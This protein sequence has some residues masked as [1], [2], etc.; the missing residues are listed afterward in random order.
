MERRLLFSDLQLLIGFLQEINFFHVLSL[1]HLTLFVEFLLC[2][3]RIGLGFSQL[4]FEI[5]FIF[6]ELN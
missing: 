3:I 2:R 6:F 1:F 4:S 5:T